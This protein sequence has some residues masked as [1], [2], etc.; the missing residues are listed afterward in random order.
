MPEQVRESAVCAGLLD[1]SRKS[2]WSDPEQVQE[3]AVAEGD[4]YKRQ[5]EERN[6]ILGQDS[7]VRVGILLKQHELVPA[8]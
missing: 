5:V 4:V 1:L 6:R 3:S 8:L 7:S 2:D